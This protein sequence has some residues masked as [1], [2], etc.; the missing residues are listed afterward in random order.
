MKVSLIYFFS[1]LSLISLSPLYNSAK[2]TKHWKKKKHIFSRYFISKFRIKLKNQIF[3]SIKNNKITLNSIFIDNIFY[4]PNEKKNNIL[5]FY[6]AL[7]NGISVIGLFIVLYK[8]LF[9]LYF[10]MLVVIL[11]KF[12]NIDAF[13]CVN[14]KIIFIEFFFLFI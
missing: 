9:F 6:F 11:L 14:C 7:L 1:L 13:P 10:N 2:I 8:I 3:I 4:T 5:I 12:V